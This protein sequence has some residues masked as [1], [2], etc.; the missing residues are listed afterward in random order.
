MLERTVVLLVISLFA[1]QTV[2][3]SSSDQAA[4]NKAISPTI[5]STQP[6]TVPA[7]TQPATVPASTQP[8]TVPASTPTATRTPVP[9]DTPTPE[10]TALP[11]SVPTPRPEPTA[12]P[13]PAP[14]PTT[15]SVPTPD[16][17]ATNV[18]TQEPELP[19]KIR[20]D[21]EPSKAIAFNQLGA[22]GNFPNQLEVQLS[23]I[24]A[25]EFTALA[26]K[27]GMSL[28]VYQDGAIWSQALGYAKEG[29]PMEPS[30]PI[31]VKSSSK[32]FL[33]ALV[34]S[35][36]QAGTYKLTDRVSVLLSNHPDYETLDK[37]IIP[38]STVFDL[39]S[40]TSG[41]SE[42][43]GSKV[44]SFMI[45]TSVDWKPS[46]TL[47]LVKDP[48]NAP[49]K[50]EYNGIVNSFLLGMIAEHLSGQDLYTLYR[51]ELLDPIEV[52]ASL[53]PVVHAPSRIA[54]PYAERSNYGGG[55]GFGDLTKV[56]IWGGHNFVE[57]DGRLSWAG[58]GIVSTS[59]NM[60]RWSYELFS[61]NGSAVNPTVRATLL[62][63][64]SEDP[65]ILAGAQQN[66]GFHAAKRNFVLSDG[67][68]ITSYGHPGGGSG[69]SSSLAYFPELD[70]AI[71][72][73]ANSDIGYMSGSCA[74]PTEYWLTPSDCITIEFL[75]AFLGISGESGGGEALNNE[76]HSLPQ[77]NKNIPFIDPVNPPK[78]A[79]S[80]FIDLDS[81]I[82]ITKLRSAYGHDYTFGDEEHDPDFNSCRSMK[83]YFD[84]YTYAQKTTQAFGDYDTKGN[85]RY[86]S[87]VAGELRDIMTNEFMLG[88]N[89]YQF[90]I[91][92]DEISNMNFSFMHVDLLEDLRKGASVEAGQHIGYVGRPYG[93]AEIVTWLILGDGKVK[94][95]SFFDVISDKI[96]S[97]YEDRG[98]VSRAQMTIPR[99]ERESNPISCHPDNGGGKFIAEGDELSFNIWQAGTDN[100]VFLN[101]P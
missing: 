89:E 35:Q 75:Q 9:T 74:S 70:L 59:E 96:F 93:Q 38:D 60:A 88:Q 77:G 29:V 90:T 8:A 31:G 26:Q 100:W 79:T 83:H 3:C 61:Q 67:T 30:T 101:I 13:T 92:S 82:K 12:V 41:I 44:E 16:P 94:Y 19:A 17:T 80:N 43:S 22:L 11:T 36:I 76:Q 10:A 5:A 15:S 91:I 57:A 95:I 54:H 6:A 42:D 20:Y 18:P 21:Y 62:N 2:G 25:E 51:T 58:A 72:V 97:E 34:L 81:V 56:P 69:T 85:M 78:I 87:P 39:L 52:Q 71:S 40:M 49:G 46:D 68:V 33:S 4:I 73:L 23:K 50:F 99:E 28:A 45:Q 14:K 84:S 86:Y 37:S 66:Y 65:V 55:A 98:V 53:L 63:S 1:V 24:F 27:A 64:F 47:T 32:T 48:P 7:S